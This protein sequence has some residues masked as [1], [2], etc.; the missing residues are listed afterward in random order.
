MTGSLCLAREQLEK[1]DNDYDKIAA[2]WAIELSK[3]KPDQRVFA[4]KS[5]E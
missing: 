4:K 3:M 5:S 1:P 2:P